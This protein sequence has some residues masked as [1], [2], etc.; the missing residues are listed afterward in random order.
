[1]KIGTK[2]LVPFLM[3]VAAV[4]ALGGLQEDLIAMEKANWTAWGKKDGATATKN[5]TADSVQTIAGVGTL[6]GRDAIAKE[7][8]AHTC[9]MKSFDFQDPKLRQL[10]P[11]VV[12]ISYTATQDTTCDG[13]KLPAKVQ[14]TTVYVKQSG[15]WLS[16]NY[17]ETPVE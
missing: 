17:Q 12:I 14:A 1:M 8:S 3:L 6:V 10:T 16:A 9:V 15:K 11:D 5:S 7:T 13:V 4:P 2:L